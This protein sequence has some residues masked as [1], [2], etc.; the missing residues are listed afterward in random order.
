MK[1][2]ICDVCG[3][4]LVMQA[5]GIASC[6]YC[7]LEYSVESLREKVMEI[8]GTVNVQGIASA[9][10]LLERAND[11]FKNGDLDKALEYF[12]KYLDLNPHDEAVKAKIVAIQAEK[13]RMTRAGELLKGKVS[14]IK[15]FGIFV[16]FYP[17]MV[18]MVHIS[19]MCDR[20]INNPSEVVALGDKIWVVCLEPDR[21]GRISYS[22]NAEEVLE[23]N[24]QINPKMR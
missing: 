2:L 23:K 11:F 20:K 17:G 6:Q 22:A 10:N 13:A 9:D 21:M 12:D 15:E 3:G 1:P 18:G 16:E 5:G 24:K 19:K 7:G 4:K 8:T 14:A